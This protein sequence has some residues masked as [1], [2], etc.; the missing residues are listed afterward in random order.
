MFWIP[1]YK[2]TV[3]AL[4]TNS[5]VYLYSW[6]YAE[7]GIWYEGDEVIFKGTVQQISCK[8]FE[9]NLLLTVF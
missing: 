8:V 5:T 3:A 7:A 9:N 1:A 4:K 2:D 6:D